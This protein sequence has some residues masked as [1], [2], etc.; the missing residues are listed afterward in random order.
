M[1]KKII[2]DQGWS[3]PPSYDLGIKPGFWKLLDGNPVRKR[4][5]RQWLARFDHENM[6]NYYN[7]ET[8]K[9]RPRGDMGPEEIH[10]DQVARMVYS[11]NLPLPIE[12]NLFY[13]L[14]YYVNRE[15]DSINFLRLKEFF[16]YCGIDGVYDFDKRKHHQLEFDPPYT[17]ENLKINGWPEDKRERYTEDYVRMMADPGEVPHN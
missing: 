15:N 7:Y 16:A 10:Y 9:G 1:A 6:R 5:F 8:G 17:L 11:A 2:S 4:F 3:I 14:D 13:H 12:K